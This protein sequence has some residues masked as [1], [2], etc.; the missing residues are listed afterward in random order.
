[1]HLFLRL[2]G[3]HLI[4]LRF[5]LFAIAC[6]GRFGLLGCSNEDARGHVGAINVVDQVFGFALEL[7]R[8]QLFPLG[9]GKALRT[10]ILR[11][12]DD[13]NRLI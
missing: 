2:R 8:L 4:V 7:V 3:A 12:F 11:A 6:L 1:V 13:L 9:L 10:I 5:L